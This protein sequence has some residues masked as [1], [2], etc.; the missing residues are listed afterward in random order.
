M[1]ERS[2]RESITSFLRERG[3]FVIDSKTNFIFAKKDGVKGTDIYQAVKKAGILIRHFA[4][5]GIEEFVR[6]SIGTKKQ[7]DLLKSV[8]GEI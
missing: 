5:P 8:L 4:T 6:I 2:E 3:W 7:M 1:Q